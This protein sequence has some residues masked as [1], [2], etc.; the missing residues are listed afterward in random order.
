MLRSATSLLKNRFRPA[1][2]DALREGYDAKKFTR[3]VLAGLI[4]GIV[5]VPLSMAFAIASGVTP[6][7]GFATGV[8]AG[9][10][11]SFLGGSRFQIGGPTGAFIVIICGII[12]THGYQGLAIAT[13]MAGVILVIMGLCGAGAVIKYI[14]YPVTVG[15]TSGIALII[16]SGQIKD[17]F[18]LPLESV[19][20]GFIERIAACARALPELNPW[21]FGFAILTVATILVLKTRASKIP[22][23]LAALLAVTALAHL[24]L[25]W[26]AAVPVETIGDRFP[27]IRDGMKFAFP[28]WQGVDFATLRGLVP[29]AI[30]IAL[31]ASIESLLS[32]VVADG[33]TGR[34]HHSNTELIAQG[35]ANIAS[36][37]FGGIPAT[38]AIARTATNIKNGAL[39]PVS[40]IV[41]AVFLLLVM[42]FLGS[43]AAH[44]PMAALGGIVAVV[45]YNMGEWR[46]FRNI[47]KSTKSDAG[48][49]LATF[50]LTVLVDLTVAIEVGVVLAAFLF[51]R[52]VSD[53]AKAGYITHLV[54][55]FENADRPVGD[56]PMGLHTRVIPK[57]VEVFEVE[58]PLFFGAAEHFKRALGEINVRPR[59]LIIR[60]RHAHSL[61]ATALQA[62]EE[63]SARSAAENTTLILSGVHQQPRAVMERSGLSAKLGAENI[64]DN[65]DIALARAAA[66]M[67]SAK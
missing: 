50:A 1:L 64:C 54:S 30:T 57:G 12:G 45:A 21:S 55:G 34:K 29:S 18:G 67:E 2:L 42:L 25:L 28:S 63:V 27:E 60:M 17:I 46:F 53:T 65:L 47:L 44:V 11:I 13:L 4:V 6:A 19:P 8:V 38:G 35:V 40:G 43:W 32:A 58:G 20:S 56:D 48:V 10:L 51:I 62:L 14:P 59:V 52:R 22:G 41:H 49:M 5:A 9:F 23:S 39:S 33:M 36:P 15:F 61:D 31:L 66:V 24:P 16:F 7:Q 37:L 3:D 26:G